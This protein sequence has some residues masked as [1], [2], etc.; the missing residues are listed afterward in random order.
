MYL[1]KCESEITHSTGSV[2]ASWTVLH[3]D[4][5][6]C[7]RTP[8]WPDTRIHLP[9]CS[10]RHQ[11]RTRTQTQPPPRGERNAER[12]LSCSWLHTVTSD[13]ET[14]GYTLWEIAKSAIYMI[15]QTEW[16]VTRLFLLC[17][18]VSDFRWFSGAVAALRWGQDAFTGFICSFHGPGICKVV[19][20]ICQK[21]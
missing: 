20:I 13:P 6:K 14:Q 4:R 17:R 2:H 8:A 7:G 18:Q 10:D 12:V 3:H 15:R 11:I 5:H 16:I 21:T 1:Y 9:Y 19:W